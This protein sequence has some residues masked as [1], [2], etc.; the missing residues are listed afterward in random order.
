MKKTASPDWRFEGFGLD[1]T[2]R[3]FRDGQKRLY[4][5]AFLSTMDSDRKAANCEW[6]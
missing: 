2:R 1:S 6:T 4:G 3:K 5:R